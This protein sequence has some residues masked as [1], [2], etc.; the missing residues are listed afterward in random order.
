MH[1]MEMPLNCK[2][3]EYLVSNIIGKNQVFFALFW[4]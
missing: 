1:F 2:S 3:T 4:Y